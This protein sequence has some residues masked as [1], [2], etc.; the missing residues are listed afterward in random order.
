MPP[1]YT[2]SL[3]ISTIVDTKAVVPINAALDNP[4]LMRKALLNAPWVPDSPPKK[5]L[6]IPPKGIHF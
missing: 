1:E 6:K 4:D 2:P 5:P 3:V